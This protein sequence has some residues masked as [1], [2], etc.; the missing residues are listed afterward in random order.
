MH[1]PLF[2]LFQMGSQCALE[3]L[4]TMDQWVPLIVY[5]DDEDSQTTYKKSWTLLT[6]TCLAPPPPPPPVVRVP[7]AGS[8]AAPRSS[9]VTT[10]MMG[11]VGVL[12]AGALL[13]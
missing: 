12:A 8:D 4:G 9:A 5:L 10:I 13:A 2:P 3:I 6:N 11:A 1:A 7:R